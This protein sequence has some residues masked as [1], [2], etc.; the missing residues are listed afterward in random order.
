MTFARFVK[1]H[2][3]VGAAETVSQGISFLTLLALARLLSPA[4]FGLAAMAMACVAFMQMLSELGLGSAVVQSRELTSRQLSSVFWLAVGFGNLCYAALFLG[5]PLVASALEAPELVATLRVLGA[6]LVVA[7]LGSM[8]IGLLTRRL[9]F[10][11]VA[12]VE[13]ASVVVSSICMLLMAAQGYGVWSLIVGLVAKLAVQT[14][15]A[16]CLEPWRPQW[17]CSI[18]T[19]KPLVSFGGYLTVSTLLWHFYTNADYLIIGKFL[20]AEL[21]GFYALAFRLATTL[22]KLLGPIL[23][24][25]SYPVFAQLQDD[26]EALA[27]YVLKVTKGIALIVVPFGVS[28]VLLAREIIEVL[29]TP[30]WLESVWP[31]RALCVVGMLQSFAIVIPHALNAKGRADLHLRYSVVSAVLLPLCFLVGVRHGIRGVGV[32]WLIG[33]PFLFGYVLRLGLGQL[34]LRAR[35]YLDNL[36]SVLVASA[37]AA[38]SIPIAQVVIG[39]PTPLARLVVGLGAALASYLVCLLIC[40]RPVLFGIRN[41]FAALRVKEAA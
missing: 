9:A 10:K 33:Y 20:G 32:A 22:V 31:F 28:G 12:M 30:R 7:A 11:Q 36:R 3:V 39:A 17:W 13:L 21:L 25:A 26:P 8:P 41:A 1:S 14:A 6:G 4:D 37:C 23:A 19:I 16:W 24:K 40:D 34:A 15:A 38:C 29:L 18:K 27:R 2:A 5:A 35:V